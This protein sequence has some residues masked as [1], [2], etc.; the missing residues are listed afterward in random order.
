MS[1][2]STKEALEKELSSMGKSISHP[3]VSIYSD[4]QKVDI[5]VFEAH[6]VQL[7]SSQ[8]RRILCARL[9]GFILR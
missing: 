7:F 8:N 3:V 5:E 2:V 6:M 4:R 1:Y 9:S